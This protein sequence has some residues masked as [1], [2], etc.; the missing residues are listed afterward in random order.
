MV[1]YT[2]IHQCNTISNFKEKNYPHDH[3]IRC[4][5]SLWQNTTSIHVKSIRMIRN[6]RYIPKYNKSSIQQTN[7]QKQTKWGESQ[8]NPTKIR[9]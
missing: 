1:Q 8:S 7:S 5:G 3:L 2:E 4:G 9:E 6:S